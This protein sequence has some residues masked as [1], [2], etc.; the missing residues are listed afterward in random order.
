MSKLWYI[1][2][3]EYYSVLKGD[4]LSKPWKDMEEA[5]MH[6]IN[7]KLKKPGIGK[8]QPTP[9]FLPGESYGQRSLA[10]YSPWNCKEGQTRLRDWTTSKSENTV[11]SWDCCQRMN[12]QSTEKFQWKYSIW[13]HNDRY[14]PLN[15]CSNPY[16]VQ[17]KKWNVNCGLC[18]IMMCQCRL[19]L[20]E[21]VP[22]CDVDNGEGNAV[23]K[24]CGKALYFLFNIFAKLKL[25]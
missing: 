14:T 3:M 2:R 23:Y 11:V 6:I 10:S 22:F 16:K 4:E 18:M 13:Y 7:T 5:S 17:H 25:F 12:R 8:L 19:F 24:I 1:Q 20:G 9:A 15:I 21:S